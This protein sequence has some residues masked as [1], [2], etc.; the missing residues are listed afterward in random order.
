MFRFTSKPMG[1]P[2]LD[3]SN[4]SKKASAFVT[5]SKADSPSNQGLGNSDDEGVIVDIV[6]PPHREELLGNTE[7]QINLMDTGTPAYDYILDQ[8]PK[9]PVFASKLL[10]QSIHTTCSDASIELEVLLRRAHLRV[11]QQQQSLGSFDSPRSSDASS[12]CSQELLRRAQLRVHNKEGHVQP[13]KQSESE[14]SNKEDAKES[15]IS[16]SLN[17]HVSDMNISQLD[18][19]DFSIAPSTPAPVRS[20]IV[21][22]I[23]EDI[24]QEHFAA[25][26]EKVQ[27]MVVDDKPTIAGNNKQATMG[28]ALSHDQIQKTPTSFLMRNKGWVL[29]LFFTGG[30]FQCASHWMAP[31][32]LVQS[33][34]SL[35]PSLPAKKINVDLKDKSSDMLLPPS[36][37][38]ATVAV[39]ADQNTWKVVLGN[40]VYVAEERMQSNQWNTALWLQL[41]ALAIVVKILLSRTLPSSQSSP[42]VKHGTG[43]YAAPLVSVPIKLPEDDEFVADF[44]LSYYENLKSTE[45]R[46]LLRLKKCNYT[47]KKDKLVHRLASLHRS[48]LQSLA[49]VQLR[50]KLKAKALKPAGLK[51]DMVRQLV[52]AGLH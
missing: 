36:T 34:V 44:D 11:Q 21:T 28:V 24:Q 37:H 47:G 25:K 51:R 10:E 49:V 2:T 19:M 30:I 40:K 16:E 46:E 29:L 48:E 50:R 13:V 5:P 26:H 42:A 41:A 1:V 32:G 43:K 8:D 39:T 18:E 6:P 14:P 17:L 22:P 15:T 33:H 35:E 12:I 27:E 38:N 9:G 4:D 23:K 3:D 45:L 7:P 20:V 52:E 31:R